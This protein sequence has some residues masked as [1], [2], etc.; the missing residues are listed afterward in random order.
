[1]VLPLVSL[2]SKKEVNGFPSETRPYRTSRGLPLSPSSA[3]TLSICNEVNIN[4]F[5]HAYTIGVC[6]FIYFY[7]YHLNNERIIEY[8]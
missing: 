3:W 7:I 6:Y 2:I 1:M 5:I 4:Y 8:S